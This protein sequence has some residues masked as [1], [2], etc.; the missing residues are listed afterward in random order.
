[1][2]A[3]RMN[4]HMKEEYSASSLLIYQNL[5]FGPCRVIVHSSKNKKTTVYLYISDQITQAALGELRF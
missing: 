1:M 2:G 5:I 4:K 3:Q